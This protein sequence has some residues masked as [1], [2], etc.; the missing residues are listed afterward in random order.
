MKDRDFLGGLTFE[1]DAILRLLNERC[2]KVIVVVSQ[3]FF[4]SQTDMFFVKFT[5]KLGIS[6][7]SIQMQVL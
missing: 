4:E 1:H 5:Q 3:A 6:E 7:K 2:R